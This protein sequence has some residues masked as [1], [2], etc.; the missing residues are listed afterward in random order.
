M[1]MS[2]AAKALRNGLASFAV[3][4]NSKLDRDLT[5]ATHNTV[6]LA[7]RMCYE[8]AITFPVVW[9][10][11]GVPRTPDGRL[12]PTRDP[13]RAA[14]LAVTKDVYAKLMMKGVYQK[15]FKVTVEV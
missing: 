8:D 1:G 2:G 4:N 13:R 3:L 7:A 9:K 12:A 15:L 5:F 14:E 11:N 10:P 6:A